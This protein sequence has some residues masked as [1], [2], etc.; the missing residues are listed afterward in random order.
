M[1]RLHCV[2]VEDVLCEVR[3]KTVKIYISALLHTLELVV[4]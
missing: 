4:G 1:V 2:T 3:V